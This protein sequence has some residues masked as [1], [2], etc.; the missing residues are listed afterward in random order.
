MTLYGVAMMPLAKKLQAGVPEVMQPWFAHDL[1]AASRAE[2]N[3]WCLDF[4][5]KTGLQYGFYPKPSKCIYICKAEDEAW[6]RK[7]FEKLT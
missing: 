7:E 3:A 6:T 4:L 1:G 2:H 5:L